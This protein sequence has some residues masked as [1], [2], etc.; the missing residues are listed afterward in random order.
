MEIAVTLQPFSYD[1]N[2][3]NKH[4]FMVQSISAPD[5][6]VNVDSLVSKVVDRLEL[7]SSYCFFIVF[8]S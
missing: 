3:K 2:E 1:M 8:S 4:K 6:E 7:L 5:G